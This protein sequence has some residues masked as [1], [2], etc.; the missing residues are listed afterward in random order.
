[1]VTPLQKRKRPSENEYSQDSSIP[2]NE[3]AATDSHG[4]NEYSQDSDRSDN[5]NGA[6]SSDSSDGD[7]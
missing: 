5:E 3:D 2:D 7:L 1:M 4:G 6:S